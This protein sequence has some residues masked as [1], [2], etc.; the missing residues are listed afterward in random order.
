MNILKN[1]LYK[2]NKYKGVSGEITL[3]NNGDLATVNYV[4]KVVRNG[5]VVVKE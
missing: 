5:K 4:T 3:D 2:F 1:E